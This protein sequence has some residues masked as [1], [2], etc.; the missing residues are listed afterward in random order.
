[1]YT[2][3]QEA[4]P[5]SVAP[6]AQRTILRQVPLN[7]S[8]T[9][10]RSARLSA[11]TSGLVLK[12]NVDA[13]SQVDTGTVLLEL[14]PELAGLALESAQAIALEAEN[15]L[16]DARRRQREARKLAPQKSIAESAVRDI[17]A[18]VLSDEAVL[19]RSQ[20]DTAYARAVLDRHIVRA[21]FAGVVS[22][23]LT[24]LGEWVTP[25]Q[26]VL[27]LVAIDSVRLDFA[28]SEDFLRAVGVGNIVSYTLSAEPERAYSALVDAVVPVANPGARTFMLRAAPGDER[29]ALRPGMSVRAVLRV[30]TGREGLV[31]PRDATLRYS[32]GRIVVWTVQDGSDG[33]VV[34]EKLVETGV[35]FDGLVEIRSGLTAGAQVVVRG[36]EALQD[37]QRVT[38]HQRL[39]ELD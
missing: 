2:H 30:P 32:D 15:A 13:G 37:G 28:V 3:A 25:G 8:V 29:P 17:E 26:A 14:D 21:P 34:T 23:K 12:L 20:A 9:A 4:V 24:E 11:A 35:Q 38:I 7:G 39:S 19:L 36:N 18:E 27:R 33:L 5:V 31:V 22:A 16:A 1:M 6:V 10:T